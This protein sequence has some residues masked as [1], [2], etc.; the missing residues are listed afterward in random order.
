M[1][2][3]YLW[4]YS[5][6]L[7]FV[8]RRDEIKLTIVNRSMITHYFR[9]ENEVHTHIPYKCIGDG[10][11]VEYFESVRNAFGRKSKCFSKDSKKKKKEKNRD[12]LWINS[13]RRGFAPGK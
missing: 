8:K 10:K 1:L 5:K 7:C 3:K 11:L 6:R 2:N 4:A 9:R 13:R 12:P